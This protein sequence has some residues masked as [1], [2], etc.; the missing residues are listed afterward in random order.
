[1]SQS[2]SKNFIVVKFVKLPEAIGW[3]QYKCIHKSWIVSRDGEN[4]FV[5]CPQQTVASLRTHQMNISEV[6]P[7]TVQF[8]T[9]ECLIFVCLSKCIY[10]TCSNLL[11]WVNCR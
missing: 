8:E 10:L 6:Y 9:G 3:L 11:G 1:M 2:T 4:V 5:A 7:A